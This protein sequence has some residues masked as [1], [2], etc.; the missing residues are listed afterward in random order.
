MLKKA[1]H[2]GVIVLLLI[3]TMGVTMYKHYCSGY[4]ISKSIGFPPKKCC[5]NGCK[6]CHNESQTFK[7]TDNY[8]STNN[9]QTFKAEVK[10]I[11]DNL[12]LAFIFLSTPS[13]SYPNNNHFTLIKICD[14]PPLIVENPSAMLQVFRL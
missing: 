13:D 8:E 5:N 9:I 12:S 7:I 4:L 11:F 2:I 14:S 6:T 10:K 1:L 3:S